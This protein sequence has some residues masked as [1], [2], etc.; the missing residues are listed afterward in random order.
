[1]EEGGELGVGGET[2]RNEL[3]DGELVDVSAVGGGEERGETEA[4]F[5]ADD[6]VLHFDGSAASDACMTKKT[7]A[8]NITTDACARSVANRE[9]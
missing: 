5:E 2:E 4:L 6:T 7:T 9:W 8:M 3:L 1:V